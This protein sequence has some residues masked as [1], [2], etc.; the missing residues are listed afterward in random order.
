[1]TDSQVLLKS[2]REIIARWDAAIREAEATARDRRF[3][4]SPDAYRYTGVAEGLRSALNDIQALLLPASGEAEPVDATVEY[5]LVDEALA[6]ATLKRAGLMIAELIVHKDRTYSAIFSPFIITSF[7]DRIAKLASVADVVIL[8]YGRL[9]NNNKSYIDFAFR[10][11][12]Q[13]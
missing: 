6:L 9:P 7:E 13:P 3:T 10:S 11:P 2:L 4:N 5:A 1:M 8:D 12:P